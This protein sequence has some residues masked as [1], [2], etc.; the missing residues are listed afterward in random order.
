MSDKQQIVVSDEERQEM[1][2][3]VEG[4]MQCMS[5]GGAAARMLEESGELQPISCDSNWYDKRW[6][7]WN[8]IHSLISKSV[9]I[10]ELKVLPK[11]E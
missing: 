4:E 2:E 6:A 7:I 10:A 5:D 3:A 11:E 9:Q 8:K 1:L